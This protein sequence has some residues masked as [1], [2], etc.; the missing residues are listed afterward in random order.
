MTE[1]EG[2]SIS[3]GGW[4][5]IQSALLV[6]HYGFEK[7]LPLWVLWLPSILIGIILIVSIIL[8]IWIAIT[9]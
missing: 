3:L 6:I 2:W 4:L 7:T 8:L 9:Y 5:F 1:S